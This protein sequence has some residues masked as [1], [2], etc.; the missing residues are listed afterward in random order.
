M[1]KPKVT[2]APLEQGKQL[3]ENVSNYNSNLLSIITNLGGYAKDI[4]TSPAPCEVSKFVTDQVCR[5]NQGTIYLATG[6]FKLGFIDFEKIKELTKSSINITKNL[7]SN[8]TNSSNGGNI[9]KLEK[10]I[11]DIHKINERNTE[12]LK[13]L[14][15]LRKTEQKGGG[16]I[17]KY[18]YI[19]NSTGVVYRRCCE[20]FHRTLQISFLQ[21]SP[22]GTLLRSL[23][24]RTHLFLQ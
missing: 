9:A 12:N 24:K 15:K 4:I 19:V 1:P 3:Y 8:P 14:E 6:K 23:E 16:N 17:D 7:L 20:R 13:V 2:I 5:I 11:N 10:N 21:F 22:L 18:T